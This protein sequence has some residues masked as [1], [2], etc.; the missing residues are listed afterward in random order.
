MMAIEKDKG[1]VVMI[2]DSEKSEKQENKWGAHS[3]GWQEVRMDSGIKKVRNG[4]T[5]WRGLHREREHLFKKRL[6]ETG[7]KVESIRIECIRV[8]GTPVTTTWLI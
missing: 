3:D 2:Q 5:C 6:A 4:D 1:L 7:N 8:V